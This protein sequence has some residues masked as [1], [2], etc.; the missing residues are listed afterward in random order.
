MI[1]VSNLDDPRCVLHSKTYGFVSVE[2]GGD[3]GLYSTKRR[4]SQNLDDLHGLSGSHPAIRILVLSRSQ[5]TSSK[6]GLTV[7]T[8]T[9]RI[10]L[11]T[12]HPQKSAGARGTRPPGGGEGTPAPLGR[13]PPARARPLRSLVP[14]FRFRRAAWLWARISL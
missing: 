9:C 7:S 2:G 6:R 3:S 4:V 10:H 14:N 5:V 1:E 13:G 11:F 8:K 12:C